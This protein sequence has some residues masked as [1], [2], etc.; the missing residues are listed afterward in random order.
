M[1]RYSPLTRRS[2]CK[3]SD[4]SV[5]PLQYYS[6]VPI[7]RARKHFRNSRNLSNNSKSLFTRAISSFDMRLTFML[8]VLLFC[9]GPRHSSAT[10]PPSPTP[11]CTTPWARTLGETNFYRWVC[12]WSIGSKSRILGA[13][14]YPAP[15]GKRDSYARYLRFLR[16]RNH[17][18]RRYHLNNLCLTDLH[19]WRRIATRE[20]RR[21][22]HLLPTKADRR[23]KGSL[24]KRFNRKFCTSLFVGFVD[25]SNSEGIWICLCRQAQFSVHPPDIPPGIIAG[26]ARFQTIKAPGGSEKELV[27]LRKCMESG[28]KQGDSVCKT[29][30]NDFNILGR[31]M[32]EACCKRARTKF[33]KS[34]FACK[35]IV[36]DDLSGLKVPV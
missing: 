8:A 27:F 13:V 3:I 5:I 25:G 33:P 6:T 12:E 10:N 4:I 9:T 26:Q 30:L 1:Y 16:C 21:C 7:K 2:M 35:A 22:A 19:K 28:K 14:I 15:S 18:H 24:R 29:S 34:K 31:H 17:V 11:V 36:P 20:I 32:L 23:E